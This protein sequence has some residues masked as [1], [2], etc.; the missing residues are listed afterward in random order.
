MPLPDSSSPIEDTVFERSTIVTLPLETVRVYEGLPHQLFESESL[1]REIAR[2]DVIQLGDFP[3]YSPPSKST[4]AIAKFL[5]DD[6]NFDLFR[7]EK[8]CGG[9]HPDY[10]VEWQYGE[11]LVCA[12]ICFGCHEV[13]IVKGEDFYRYDMSHRVEPEKLFEGFR[14]KRPDYRFG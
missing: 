13:L 6:S 8:R 4:A 12:Q 3:F 9:F 7:G 2:D 14:T 10:A 1:E 11:N 5:S